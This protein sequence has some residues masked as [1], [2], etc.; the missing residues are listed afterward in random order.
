[1]TN[2]ETAV[3]LFFIYESMNI[4]GYRLSYP[5]PLFLELGKIEDYLIKI[6][7]S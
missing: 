5:E 3:K 1:M 4:E 7:R 2:I 6:F